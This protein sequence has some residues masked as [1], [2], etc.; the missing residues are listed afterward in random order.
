[1]TKPITM[2]YNYESF[3]LSKTHSLFIHQAWPQLLSKYEN[4]I[5]TQVKKKPSTLYGT[6]KNSEKW[7]EQNEKIKLN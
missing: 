3:D 5:F 1:M 6:W 2:L 4:M 7:V